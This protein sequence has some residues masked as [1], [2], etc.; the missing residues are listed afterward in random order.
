ML[1]LIQNVSVEL[2]ASAQRRECDCFPRR[3][4]AKVDNLFLSTSLHL[5][6]IPF[7]TGDVY[8]RGCSCPNEE[9]APHSPEEM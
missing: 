5:D 6:E 3:P 8:V 7:I 2:S 9:V 1:T 4:S